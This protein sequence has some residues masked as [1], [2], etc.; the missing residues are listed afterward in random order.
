MLDELFFKRRY[1]NNPINYIFFG[2]LMTIIGIFS[3]VFLFGLDSS[4]AQILMVTILLMP[5]VMRL[6]RK[7]EIRDKKF[8]T[9]NFYENHKDVVV[10][11]ICLF[12]GVFLAYLILQLASI[13]NIEWFKQLF[14]YQLNYIEV[15]EKMTIGL[16]ES[17]TST[18]STLTILGTI[19]SLSLG[20][21]SVAFFLSIFYGSG[22]IFILVLSGSIFSTLF[23]SVM[24]MFEF[25]MHFSIFSLILF[26]IM[27]IPIQVAFIL[28]SI[29]GGIISK[30]IVSENFNKPSFKLVIKDGIL[31]FLISV[32]IILVGVVGSFLVLNLLI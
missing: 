14:S 16:I 8:G 19:L 27:F 20:L 30:A 26:V 23:V 6:L 1:H 2:F 24:Q 7:A 32:G 18:Q 5:P 9:K 29:A 3:A 25:F 12:L 11:F 13:S 22:G 17:L 10:V 21:I 4:V 28:S 31:L 15:N